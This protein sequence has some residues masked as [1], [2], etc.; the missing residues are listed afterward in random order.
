[1]NRFI[2]LIL[3]CLGF[4]QLMAQL[5]GNSLTFY[6]S[7]PKYIP[8]SNALYESW[9]AQM[10]YTSDYFNKNTGYAEFYGTCSYSDQNA[11][12]G[13]TFGNARFGLYDRRDISLFYNYAFKFDNRYSKHQLAFA[14]NPTIMFTGRFQK[15]KYRDSG[16]KLL[17][18]NTSNQVRFDVGFSVFYTVKFNR[19][20]RNYAGS[21]RTLNLGLSLPYFMSPKLALT[22]E[23]VAKIRTKHHFYNLVEYHHPLTALLGLES[24]LYTTFTTDLD[25]TT[26]LISKLVLYENKIKFG[27]GF[28]SRKRLIAVSSFIL[29]NEYRDYLVEI[30]GLFAYNT[31][32]VLNRNS[33]INFGVEI[34]YRLR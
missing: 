26:S 1:M 3:A 5:D 9:S 25:W 22:N 16:D 15:F 24:G 13:L 12:F 7:V 29:E 17:S 19:S 11:Q 20:I 4:N 32:S 14:M 31:R 21:K 2:I 8:A 18:V 23:N 30:G 27:L 34:L 6:S 33:P 28:S 10:N